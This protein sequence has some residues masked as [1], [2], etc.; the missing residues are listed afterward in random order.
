MTAAKQALEWVENERRELYLAALHPD[1]QPDQIAATEQ[2]FNTLC[3][4]LRVLDAVE[5][6]WLVKETESLDSLANRSSWR[7]NLGFNA[8]LE[9]LKRIGDEND[10]REE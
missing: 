3:R 6:G 1:A 7:R 4:A 10:E 5:S 9:Q 8:C 2:V